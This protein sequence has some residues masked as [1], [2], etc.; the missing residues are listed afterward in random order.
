MKAKEILN[1][2]E[3]DILTGHEFYDQFSFYFIKKMKSI[4]ANHVENNFEEISGNFILIDM[5]NLKVDEKVIWNYGQELSN[6]IKGST[7][8]KYLKGFSLLVSCGKV[9]I[10]DRQYPLQIRI[11][12]NLFKDKMTLVVRTYGGIIQILRNFKSVPEK[13]LK[14]SYTNIDSIAKAIRL[15]PIG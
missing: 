2:C 9:T 6:T 15:T 3:N 8:I 7:F 12:C 5:K 13:L 11:S 4:G 10:Q 14:N 1:L